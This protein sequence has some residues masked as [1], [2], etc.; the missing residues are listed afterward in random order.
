MKERVGVT[1][2]LMLVK[3]VKVDLGGNVIKKHKIT[4]L[5]PPILRMLVMRFLGKG[6][7]KK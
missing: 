3:R 6:L 4:C 1:N 7:L 2:I 5:R